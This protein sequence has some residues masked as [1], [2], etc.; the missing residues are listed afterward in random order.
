MADKLK[1]SNLARQRRKQQLKSTTSVSA[2]SNS[3]YTPAYLEELRQS[4]SA[5]NSTTGSTPVSRSIT[6]SKT[7]EDDVIINV[8]E[9]VE[10]DDKDDEAYIALDKE[11]QE[12][13]RND[14][15]MEGKF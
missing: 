2:V 4:T 12:V 7:I 15:D 11:E 10:Q 13:V 6:P 1:I 3:V 9:Q 8:T 14:F 5:A